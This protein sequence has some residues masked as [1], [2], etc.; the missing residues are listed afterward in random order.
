MFRCRG[1][2]QQKKKTSPEEFM[3]PVRKMRDWS[4]LE[5][6]TRYWTNLATFI[7]T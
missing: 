6:E 7:Y 5:Q 3:I 4:A 1:E 2:K